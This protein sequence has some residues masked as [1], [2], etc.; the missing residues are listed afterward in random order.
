MTKEDGS[1]LQ[2]ICSQKLRPLREKAESPKASTSAEVVSYSGDGGRAAIYL[3]C[4]INSC[5]GIRCVQGGMR[6]SWSGGGFCSY[7]FPAQYVRHDWKQNKNRNTG[8]R[9]EASSVSEARQHNRWE[10][11]GYISKTN[12][13]SLA[14]VH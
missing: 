7:G 5:Q 6:G 2:Q 10:F 3:V 11:L 12:I 9:P 8:G 14:L 1:R 13:H 4:V